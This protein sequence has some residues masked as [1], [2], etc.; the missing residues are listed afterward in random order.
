MSESNFTWERNALEFE[1]A[2]FP[3]YEPYGVWSNFKFIAKDGSVN[4]ADLLAFRKMGIFFSEI[5]SRPGT[6]FGDGWTWEHGGR[7]YTD[8]NPVLLADRKCKNLLLNQEAAAK[9]KGRLP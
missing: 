5:K 4:E 7:R 8:E 3:G 6:I 1:R 2:Q 9:L